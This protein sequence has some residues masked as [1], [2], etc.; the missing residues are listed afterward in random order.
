MIGYNG[1]MPLATNPSFVN[2]IWDHGKSLVLYVRTWAQQRVRNKLLVLG[3]YNTGTHPP[4]QNNVPASNLG[5]DVLSTSTISGGT[6][7]VGLGRNVP[8]GVESAVDFCVPNQGVVDV[9]KANV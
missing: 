6:T 3:R 7:L 2:T 4:V 5:F 9:P 8:V 1:V